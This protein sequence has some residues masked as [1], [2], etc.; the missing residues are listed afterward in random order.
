[1]IYLI[2]VFLRRVFACDAYTLYKTTTDILKNDTVSKEARWS[3]A[4]Q[5]SPRRRYISAGVS[6][7]HSATQ[8]NAQ[9]FGAFKAP[10]L[11]TVSPLK[12]QQG[13]LFKRAFSTYSAALL[14]LHCRGVLR[15]MVFPSFMVFPCL[16]VSH[17]SL[18][19]YLNIF[20]LYAAA[21]CNV[22]ISDM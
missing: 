17:C 2:K 15:N 7:Q 18:V 14:S 13:A 3:G 11:H 8:V 4:V 1:M 20:I 12:P 6:S 5:V 22:V 16:N 19:R 10:I 21:N 9:E